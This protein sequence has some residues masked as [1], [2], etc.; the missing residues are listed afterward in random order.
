VF[1]VKLLPLA[2]RPVIACPEHQ[3]AVT[4]RALLG[5]LSDLEVEVGEC[6][7]RAKELGVEDVTS[8]LSNAL[9]HVLAAAQCT[10]AVV[11]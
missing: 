10:K 5:R 7:H 8:E 4:L 2:Q 6:R 11:R 9:L 1:T 3:R